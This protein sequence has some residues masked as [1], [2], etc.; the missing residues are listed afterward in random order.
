MSEAKIIIGTSGWSYKHWKGAFYPAT[1]RDNQ[2]FEFYQKYFNTVEINNSFYHL[3]LE[4]TFTNWRKET[5]EDFTFAVKASRYITHMKKLKNDDAGLETFLKRAAKLKEK[6]G[7]V[8]FQLPPSWKL[9]FERLENFV[10]ALPDKHR[11]TFEFRNHSW[12]D[13]SVIELLTRHNIAFCIYELEHH[14]SPLHVTA[15]FVY[16]RLH[17]PG[18]KY[19]G[20]YSK[21]E[22]KKWARRCQ[23]WQKEGRDVYVFFDNDQSGYAAFNALTLKE[24]VIP[25]KGQQKKSK[26]KS[27]NSS[28]MQL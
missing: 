3:P 1:I 6:L 22:L 18:D 10:K 24:L 25:K 16:I 9:N 28:Q 4:K 2:E 15:D 8:L 27:K 26:T 13:E 11:Y 19:Q 17:G 21:A 12:Y 23:N 20:Y 5:A 7:P 14:L